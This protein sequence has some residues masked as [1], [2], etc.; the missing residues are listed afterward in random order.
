M[1]PELKP[2]LY[3]AKESQTK[4]EGVK[5]FEDICS[6]VERTDR[7]YAERLRGRAM[8]YLVFL[9]YPFEIRRFIYTTNAIESIN[10][11][12][13]Y[14]RREL[15]GYFPSKQSFSI[16][17]FVQVVNM[18]DSSMRTPLLYQK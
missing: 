9:S 18:S 17:Y 14:I 12:L 7:A 10:S 6:I 13:D 11:G 1:Y 5:H 16:N 3:L 2:H 4:E 15:R 8:N